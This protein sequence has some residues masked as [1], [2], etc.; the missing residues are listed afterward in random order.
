MCVLVQNVPS[1]L[2]I[3]LHNNGDNIVRDKLTVDTLKY[4][5]EVKGAAG[6]RS[7]YLR[8]NDDTEYDS[9]SY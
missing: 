3:D 9:G 6:A 1:C 7:K 8:R 5:N 4:T 2:R